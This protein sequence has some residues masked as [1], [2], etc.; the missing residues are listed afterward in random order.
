[1]ED[2]M[3]NLMDLSLEQL[4]FIASYVEHRDKG[5]A[6]NESGLLDGRGMIDP[7][8]A[9]RMADELLADELVSG[10]INRRLR[11][12]ATAQAVSVNEIVDELR[13]VAFFDPRKLFDKDGNI[14]PVHDLDNE[15]AA[16]LAHMDVIT[17]TDQATVTKV[18][19]HAKMKALELL[20]KHKKMFTDKVE[21]EHSGGGGFMLTWGLEPGDD[22]AD[23]TQGDAED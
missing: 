18:V 5:K 9:I 17:V 20:G 16:A 11:V 22:G 13:K 2:R 8:D 3:N 14:R 1:M 10:E 7:F 21:H 19:P 6:I 4:L 15:E 23:L 12:A